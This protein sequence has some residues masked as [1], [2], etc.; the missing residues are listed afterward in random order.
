M[1]NSPDFTPKA[2]L[3]DRDGVI[4]F[5][6]PDYILTPDQWLP[7][8]GSLEAIAR[9]HAAGIRIAIVSNQ[10]ALG[11]G[12]VD[13][14]TFNAIHGKMMLA[15]EQAGGFISHVAYCP[16]GPDDCCSCRK[17]LPGMVFESLAAL[18]IPDSP[19][20]AL[21]IGD[22]VRDVQAA[23]AARVPAMLVQSGYGD[24]DAILQKSRQLMPEIRAF[25]DL[26]SAVDFVLGDS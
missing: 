10:S 20:Q 15:I 25:A 19:E 26:A 12:M 3:L 24:S 22:S 21:F 16:H 14:D 6:S 18:G 1:T 4:N 2:V 9:L 23:F 5:D 11:R 17:P 13:R 8:P 7:V